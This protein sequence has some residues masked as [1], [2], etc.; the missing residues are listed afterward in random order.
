MERIHVPSLTIVLN[1]LLNAVGYSC[2]QM[3]AT[4][5]VRRLW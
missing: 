5:I 3:P 4:V 1:N 2:R